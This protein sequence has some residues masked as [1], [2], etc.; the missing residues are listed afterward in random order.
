MELPEWYIIESIPR[1][2]RM[3]QLVPTCAFD[4]WP[5]EKTEGERVAYREWKAL[6]DEQTRA[7]IE[8]GL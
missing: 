8:V 5:Y 4:K 2:E 6:L 1:L 7:E 3:E